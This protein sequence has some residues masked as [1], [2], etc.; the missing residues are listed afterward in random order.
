MA[1]CN[2]RC[3]PA[4]SSTTQG[5]CTARSSCGRSAAA[6]RSCSPGQQR[7]SAELVTAVLSRCVERVGGIRAS[8]R[9]SCAGCSSPTASSSCSSCARRRSGSGPGQ[10]PVPV[11]GLRQARGGRAS[12]PRRARH[13]VAGQGARLR[14]RPH[15]RRRCPVPTRSERTVAFRLPIGADQEALSPLLDVNEASALAGLLASCVVRVGCDGEP[16]RR[17]WRGFLRWLARRS[18]GTCSESRRASTLSWSCECPG[19][20]RQFSAPFDVQRF[21]FG[22]L[23]VTADLLLPRGPLP[24]L[25]LPLERTRDH[26]DA[27]EPAPPATSTVLAD[28]I[29]RLNE[30][31]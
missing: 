2:A 28:E 14:V 23:R 10:R 27:A 7:E 26:G 1:Q 19:C 22:E 8:T 5:T 21:F 3:C 30:P 11:A 9:T 31:A 18:S 15:T 17:P 4:A 29:D 24:R 25:P 20:G 12:R 13:R 6:R 16:A